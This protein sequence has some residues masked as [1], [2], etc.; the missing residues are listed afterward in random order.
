VFSERF[1]Y[2]YC[3][4]T[5]IAVFLLFF[6]G[7]LVR[8]TGSGMGCPDW[9]KCFGKI[10][11]PMSAAELPEDY[12]EKVDKYINLLNKL[13]LVKQ[14]T[15]IGHSPDLFEAHEFSASKAYTEYLN[16]VFGVLTGILMILTLISSFDFIKTSPAIP[17][18]SFS[19]FVMIVFNG[20]L[21][22]VVVDTNLISGIVTTHFL[23]SLLFVKRMT[24]F[25]L[26]IIGIQILS[27]TLVR[28]NIHNSIGFVLG[29]STFSEL[30]SGFAFHRYTS[31]IVLIGCV[32]LNWRLSG[33]QGNSKIVKQVWLMTILAFLQ[34][35]VG[36]FNII[37]HLP[38]IAIVLHITF[39][40]ALFVLPLNLYL[41]LN[42]SDSSV[43][44]H[45]TH[46]EKTT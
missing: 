31:I 44:E 16:R 35:C 22:S 21:G 19:A 43:S 37:Y 5:I 20:W 1:F 13:G 28:E 2:K 26:L 18:F 12:K 17:F 23:L 10:V 3:L 7:G 14:A 8:A 32:Y 41:M 24:V 29:L 4:L 34:I 27:G 46:T 11:P 39:G 45:A 15:A 6:F 40:A 30:G 25:I 42:H 38:P 9:P 36:A 33:N